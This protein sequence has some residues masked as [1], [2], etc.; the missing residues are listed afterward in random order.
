ME[1]LRRLW[2]IHA[3]RYTFEL[4]DPDDSKAQSRL[5]ATATQLL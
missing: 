3:S 4:S 5:E 1:E 2:E